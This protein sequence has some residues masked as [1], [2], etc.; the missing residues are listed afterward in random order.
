MYAAW[1]QE[2]LTLKGRGA[3]HNFPT[4]RQTFIVLQLCCPY[5]PDLKSKRKVSPNVERTLGG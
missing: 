3:L 5:P 4:P 2:A 1:L